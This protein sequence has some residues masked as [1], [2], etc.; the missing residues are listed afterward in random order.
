MDI[1]AKAKY[2]RI[3]PRKVRLVADLVRGKKVQPALDQLQ[4]SPKKAARPVS[5]LIQSAIA[6]AV[7]NYELV[8]SNLYIKEIK[9]DEGP[10]LKRWLPRA[11]GRA[12]IL[13]KKMSHINVILGEIKDSGVKQ[14][15]QQKVEAPVQLG[16]KKKEA[17]GVKIADKDK[18]LKIPKTGNDK[19]SG[20]EIIDQ[21]NEGHG[22][23]VKI[24]DNKGF[25]KKVFRR[26][27]G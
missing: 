14:A 7:N 23:N 8:E 15:K 20:K 24:E 25:A 19:D 27:S 11:H 6:N 4:F 17:E 22:K 3:A 9:V 1:K 18:A 2:I 21:H 5:K 16:Q 12:T 13:R 26:K 10:V